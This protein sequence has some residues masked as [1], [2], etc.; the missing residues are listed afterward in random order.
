VARIEDLVRQSPTVK[1]IAK[2]V[3]RVSPRTYDFV[4][5]LASSRVSRT[6]RAL[7]ALH[8]ENKLIARNSPLFAVNINGRMGLGA[9]MSHSVMVLHYCEERGLLPRLMFTNPVYAPN[10]GDDWLDQYFVRKKKLG[11]GELAL[12]KE[13][14]LPMTINVSR[15]LHQSLPT[16][17]IRRAHDLFFEYLGIRNEILQDVE[18]FCENHAVG[19]QTVGVHFRGTDK[20]LEASR[21]SWTTLAVAVEGALARGKSNIF[22]AT[23]EPEFLEYMAN[24]FGRAIV[25]DLGCKEI[26]AGSVPAHL[27]PGDPIQKAHEAIQSILTLSRCGTL[28]R[29]R[30]HLSAWAKIFNPT[31]PHAVFGEMLRGDQFIFPENV[32]EADI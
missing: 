9:V 24:R 17:T 13:R 18:Q 25:I 10:P 6:L 21:V 28:F 12:P 2:V 7:P 20:R 5:R 4:I 1:A 8:R 16:L 23:D 31:L 11:M 3:R 32:V 14:F 29:T 15:R 19:E 27:A 22:V 26:F 30:S